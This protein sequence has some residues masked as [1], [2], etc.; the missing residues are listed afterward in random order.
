MTAQGDGQGQFRNTS[1]NVSAT[2]A[3]MYE[4]QQ[5]EVLCFKIAGRWNLC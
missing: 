3:L 5:K 2:Q 4:Y 1:I